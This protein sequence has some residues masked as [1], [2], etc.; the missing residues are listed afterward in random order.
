M[1][2]TGNKRLLRLSPCGNGGFGPL[3]LQRNIGAGHRR[4]EPRFL[5]QLTAEDGL[6]AQQRFDA[7]FA[8]GAGGYRL[9]D[10]RQ[11]RIANFDRLAGVVNTA[12]IAHPA[13]HAQRQQREV[14]LVRQVSAYRVQHA[15]RQL[16][17]TVHGNLPGTVF[18]RRIAVAVNQQTGI[19]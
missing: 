13:R 17:A 15:L 14:M 9:L 1:T 3:T 16:L 10:H 6:N 12:D 11:Q 19:V 5:R 18:E 2:D 4:N 7:R 8:I